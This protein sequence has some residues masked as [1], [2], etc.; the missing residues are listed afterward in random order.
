MYHTSIKVTGWSQKLGQQEAVCRDLQSQSR[1]NL[2][3]L[4]ANPVTFCN[5]QANLK[6]SINYFT[7]DMLDECSKQARTTRRAH[8]YFPA[9]RAQ[10]S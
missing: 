10:S 9:H 2:T 5:L 6:R 1:D 8:K 3:K 7:D 4:R